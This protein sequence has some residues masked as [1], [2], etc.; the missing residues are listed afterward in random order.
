MPRSSRFILLGQLRH[1]KGAIAG[2][3]GRFFPARKY[4]LYG[5]ESPGYSEFSILD[6]GA[7][8]RLIKNMLAQGEVK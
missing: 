3:I 6:L 5:N 4:P 8:I 7:M 1:V 2:E